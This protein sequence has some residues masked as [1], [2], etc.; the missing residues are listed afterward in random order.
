L[1]ESLVFGKH[2]P[3]QSSSSHAAPG[4]DGQAGHLM[5]DDADDTAQLPDFCVRMETCGR[6]GRGMMVCRG[7]TTS[8]LRLTLGVALDQLH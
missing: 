4:L 7:E 5:D 6:R 1:P 2:C 3:I 8:G